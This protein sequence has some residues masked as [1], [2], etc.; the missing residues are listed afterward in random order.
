VPRRC[1]CDRQQ[2]TV[3]GNVLHTACRRAVHP[4]RHGGTAGIGKLCALAQWWLQPI[5]AAVHRATKWP[6]GVRAGAR[7]CGSERHQRST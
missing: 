4:G 2:A 3:G 7:H 6:E 5:A 1:T